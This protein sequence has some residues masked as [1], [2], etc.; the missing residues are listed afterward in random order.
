MIQV[1]ISNDPTTLGPD[2]T[3]DDLQAYAAALESMLTSEFGARDYIVVRTGSVERSEA[4]DAD[5]ERRVHEIESSD[6]WTQI[7]DAALTE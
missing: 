3:A 2:A 6:E 1:T 5:V 7:L 4:T